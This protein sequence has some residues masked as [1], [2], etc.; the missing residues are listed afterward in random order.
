[1]EP[2]SGFDS[3]R[4]GKLRES[5][6]SSFGIFPGDHHKRSSVRVIVKPT[7]WW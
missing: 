5:A 1:M 2:T 7:E 4:T 3:E 6:F